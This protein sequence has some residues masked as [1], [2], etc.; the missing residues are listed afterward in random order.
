MS[1]DPSPGLTDE[2]EDGKGVEEREKKDEVRLW[3]GDKGEDVGPRRESER[4]RWG[5]TPLSD[6]LSATHARCFSHLC[7]LL[8]TLTH[9]AAARTHIHLV[10]RFERL[11]VGSAH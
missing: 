1:E 3:R 11:S 8:R 10:S 2:D 7:L 4:E 5:T 9:A 6:H